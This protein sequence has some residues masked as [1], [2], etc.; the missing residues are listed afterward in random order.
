MARPIEDKARDYLI[1]RFS[2]QRYAFNGKNPDEQGFDLWMKDKLTGQ[3]TKIELKATEGSYR[4]PSDIF[5][6]L[7]FSARNEVENFKI[8]NTKIVRVFLGST[9]PRVFLLDRAILESGACFEEEFR[10][11]IVGSKN[12][13]AICEIT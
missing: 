6:Q 8:G 9:T 2:H 10:A 1:N 4:K 7:Y 5:Q 13:K 11:K 3:V 12:Y